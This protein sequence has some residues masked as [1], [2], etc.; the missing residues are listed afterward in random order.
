MTTRSAPCLPRPS[1]ATRSCWRSVRK[2]PKPSSLVVSTAAPPS[3]FERP[4]F[5]SRSVPFKLSETAP[6]CSRHICPSDDL[7]DE[8]H[9]TAL[10]FIDKATESRV[11]ASL[12]KPTSHPTQPLRMR[13]GPQVV[14][15][16]RV[17]GLLKGAQAVELTPPSVEDSMEILMVQ[18]AKAAAVPQGTA[19]FLG[20][21]VLKQRLSS[22]RKR[23]RRQS[24]RRVPRSTTGRR[25]SRSSSSATACRSRSSWPAGSLCSS[26]SGAP[27]PAATGD[28]RRC[29]IEQESPL[30]L[31][32]AAL[33]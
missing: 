32:G 14:I 6:Y 31:C 18:T 27:L 2:A 17:R 12:N 33:R 23:R 10:N 3:R 16:T 1:R 7:W 9:E 29:F 28:E 5:P 19:G 25:R 24:S 8:A 11:S 26:T 4:R 21:L 22:L 30:F 13:C 20:F 15:S